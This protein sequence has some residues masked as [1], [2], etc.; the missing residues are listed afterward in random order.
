MTAQQQD[1]VQQWLET[2][3]WLAVHANMSPDWPANWAP[4]P[5]CEEDCQGCYDC[6]VG[7]H[8]HP[9]GGADNPPED[10]N[11]ITAA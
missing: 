4:L 8:L 3:P 11:P 9:Y 7:D 1:Q 6:V 5:T 2:Q 10:D